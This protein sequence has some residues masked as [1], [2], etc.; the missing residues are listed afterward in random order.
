MSADKQLIQDLAVALRDVL[1][2][3]DAA[4]E[5]GCI[6]H[7]DAWDDANEQWDEPVEN[8]RELLDKIPKE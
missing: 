5:V 6:D 7:L 4:E 2:A 8:A 1:A 3:I